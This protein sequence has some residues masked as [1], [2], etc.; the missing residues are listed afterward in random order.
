MIFLTDSEL[1]VSIVTT[2]EAAKVMIEKNDFDAIL[3]DVVLPGQSGYGLC[4]SLRNQEK[5]KKIPIIICSSK[6]A[7]MDQ[8]WGMKQGANAYVTKPI[9]TKKVEE[10]L[11]KV[12][13]I[14]KH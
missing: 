14:L 1:E 4:I 7:N 9:E 3:M 13:I 10:A 6:S 2:A 5:T 12:G 11:Q 8:K